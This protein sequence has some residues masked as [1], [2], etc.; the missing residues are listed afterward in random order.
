MQNVKTKEAKEKLRAIRPGRADRV[1]DVIN[2]IVLGIA[3]L[4][5]AY[6]LYFI[7]IASVSDPML[8]NAGKVLLYPKGLTLLGYERI[9]SIDSVMVGYKNTILYTATGTL[10]SLALTLTGGYALSRQSLPF[11][12]FFTSV[13]TITM[14]LHGGTIPM[15]LLIKKLGLL[16][17][18]WAVILPGALSV[19]NM[20]I[21]RTFYTANITEDLQ[22]AADID[23][24]GQIRFFFVIAMPLTKALVAILALY[25]MVGYWNSYFSAVM[26]LKSASRFPL[27]LVLRE[28]LIMDQNQE[29]LNDMWDIIERQ[30]TA[31][32]VKYGVIIVSTLPLMG[33]YPFVQKFFIKGVMI[34]SLKG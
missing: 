28:I 34:G 32:L 16:D 10:M 9:F 24:C 26:Y 21:A 2:V 5:T 15:Y 12:K 3:L 20:I 31:E 6:P 30:K 4:I 29:M 17:S 25:Y 19:W 11:R 8:V 33:I 14:F 18:M 27:Q 1:F 7:L 23:G 22:G 13:F